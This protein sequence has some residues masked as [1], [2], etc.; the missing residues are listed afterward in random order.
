MRLA[1]HIY[2]YLDDGVISSFVRR[3][4]IF[5]EAADADSW[6][7]AD[8]YDL[9]SEIEEY[10]RQS[11]NRLIVDFENGTLRGKAGEGYHSAEHKAVSRTSSDA[12]EAIDSIARQRRLDAAANELEKLKLSAQRAASTV[13]EGELSEAFSS[14]GDRENRLA[15]VFRITAIC[16][17][18]LL[19]SFS[20]FSAAKL[21]ASL[22]AS[23][24]HVG[25]GLSGLAAFG[26]MARESSQHRR[27]GRWAKVMSV[28]LRT[29]DAYAADME[30]E[31]RR[32]LREQFARRVFASP[33][34][35][36]DDAGPAGATT[37]LGPVLE[38]VMSLIKVARGT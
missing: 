1:P 26:Y 2:L 18:L 21:P 22:G 14:Y 10:L 17:L 7:E 37:D 33:E 4:H 8:A 5:A 11:C 20:V 13:A 24:A 3:L 9:A 28:Q 34:Y 31:Q 38:A 32:A 29:L 36:L 15:E 23:L 35:S 30:D 16:L 27:A 6:D 19:I 25:I 12:G